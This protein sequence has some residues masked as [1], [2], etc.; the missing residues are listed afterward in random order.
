MRLITL[1]IGGVA[2]PGDVVSVSYSAKRGGKTSGS[3]QVR[4][5][6]TLAD[7]AQ[8]LAFSINTHWVQGLFDAKAKGETIRVQCADGADDVTFGWR[9]ERI[10]GANHLALAPGGDITVAIEE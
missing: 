5:G 10:V 3:H 4:E 2:T 7:V 9:V 1:T 6:E 8:G